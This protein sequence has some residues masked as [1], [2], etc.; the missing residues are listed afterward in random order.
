VSY[1]R[2]DVPAGLPPMKPTTVAWLVGL[3]GWTVLLAFYHLEGGARFEPTDCWVA[4]TAREMYEGHS[5]HS[6]VIPRFSGETR[7]QKS[8]GP[9][10][11]VMLTAWLRGR[12]DIDEAC[13][14]IP[15]GLAGI[16]IVLTVFWLTRRLAGDR[17]AIYAGFA[18]SASV[19]ILYWSH[20]GASDLGLAAL[21]TVS[22]AALWVAAEQEPPGRRQTALWLLGYFAAGLGMLYKLPMPLAIIGAPVLVYVLIKRR[23]SVLRNRVHLWGILLFL[24]PWL[25]WAVT[26]VIL[27]PTALAKWKV[28]FWDRFTGALPNVEGQRAWYFHLIYLIPPIVYCLPFSLSLPRALARAFTRQP[29]VNR[30]GLHFAAIWFVALFAFFTASAGKELRYFLPALPPL[31]VLLGIELADFFDPERPARPKR[32][33]FAALAVWILVPLG[34]IGGIFGVYR[35][36]RAVGQLENFAWPD[37]WKPYVVTAL[38]F[39]LGTA[40][41]AWLYLARRRNASFAA[42]VGTMWLS[43]LWIWPTIMPVF[44]AQRPFVDFATQLQQKIDP[45]L[46]DRIRQ[47]GSQDSR[48][49]WYSDVRFPRIIDQLELLRLQGGQRSLERET[50]LVGHAM[51]DALAGDDPVLLVASRPYFV[52]FLTLA[53]AELAALDRHMPPVYI[54]LQTS[55]GPKKKHFVLFGNRPPPWPEPALQPPSERLQKYRSAQPATQPTTAS[56]PANLS[57]E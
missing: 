11:S 5:A 19:M 14:R 52:D 48:I 51:A 45:A 20:R 18:C 4:Q 24:L 13:T 9:Y 25:P 40:L 54:W 28:E 1:H 38:L 44:A 21:T 23:W 36:Y 46:R 47:V 12:A 15:N 27:E 34:F 43:W 57:E 49:I 50:Q 22:L 7:M 6:L 2:T 31:F 29:G 16:L 37:V 30:D 10:W 8:P 17:A 56:A 35:W 3:I 53:P 32:D 55:L 42:L 33:R 26:T 41:A 39:S